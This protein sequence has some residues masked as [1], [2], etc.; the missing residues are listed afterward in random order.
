VSDLHDITL[1]EL[2]EGAPPSRGRFD[3]NA[4]E[5]LPTPARRYLRHAIAEGAPLA[6]AVRLEMHGHIKLGKRWRPFEAEQVIRWDRGLIWKAKTKMGPLSIAGSDRL[7]DGQGAMRWKL[8]GV[9]PV[10]SAEGPDVTRSAAGRLE[11]ESMWLPS[12][13]L[14]DGIT[15]TAQDDTHAHVRVAVMGDEAELALTID[16]EGRLR[17]TA[18]QRWGNPEGEAFHEAPFGAIVEEE[19]TFEGYTIPTKLRVGWHFDTPRFEA[20]GEFWRAEITAATYR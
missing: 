18:M 17:Q 9:V 7:I 12:V 2:W 4:L 1:D 3:P 19:S 10:M 6:A 14:G 5:G 8:L 16:P 20:E 11:A 13:L 15:W